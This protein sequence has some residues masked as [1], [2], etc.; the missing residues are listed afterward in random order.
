MIN[1]CDH[2]WAESAYLSEWWAVWNLQ[3]M[4]VRWNLGDEFDSQ[5]EDEM[6]HAKIF[7]D[8][9][10]AEDHYPRTMWKN[11][12]GYPINA[13]QEAIYRNVCGVDLHRLTMHNV[14]MFKQ[15]HELTERRAIWIY[16]TYMKGGT[17]ERY[18]DV[19]RE[20]IEDEKGHIHPRPQSDNP[21]L[22]N[23]ITT[24]KWV[25][26]KFLPKLYNGMQLLQC[27]AFWNDYYAGDLMA[28]EV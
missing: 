1:I 21:I 8:A 26:L 2:W 23:L 28:E 3:Q 7:L 15:V 22:N 16:K 6:R 13:M 4:A 9:M 14:D 17:V 19:C 10:A 24:D 20:I 12:E 11:S 18:K 5:I 27:P 25:F